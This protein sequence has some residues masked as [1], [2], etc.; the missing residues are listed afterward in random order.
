[1]TSTRRVRLRPR[2]STA[3]ELPAGSIDDRAALLVEADGA[4]DAGAQALAVSEALL[5]GEVA[6]LRPAPLRR[7][8]LAE[9]AA[10]SPSPQ[11]QAVPGSAKVVAFAGAAGFAAG[12]AGAGWAWAGGSPAG[13]GL[14]APAAATVPASTARQAAAS[15]SGPARRTIGIEDHGQSPFEL[16]A[17]DHRK[18]VREAPGRRHPGTRRSRAGDG[19]RPR[20]ECRGPAP[21]RRRRAR[22]RG[23]PSARPGGPGDG[24]SRARRPARQAR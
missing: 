20:A 22:P 19:R 3:T 5:Q 17:V 12:A 21:S 14:A 18:G 9:G 24:T 15:G 16:T 7:R 2:V 1:M 6:A 4:V 23:S 11:A 8:V 13:E 10:E